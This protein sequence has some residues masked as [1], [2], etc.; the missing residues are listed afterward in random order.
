ML[1]LQEMGTAQAAQKNTALRKREQRSYTMVCK[2]ILH[3]M[4]QMLL[5]HGLR[6]MLGQTRDMAK[7]ELFSLK[8]IIARKRVSRPSWQAR[9]Q[10]M[11]RRLLHS[12]PVI[13]VVFEVAEVAKWKSDSVFRR[14]QRHPR[15]NPVLWMVPY[16]IG[17]SRQN[18]AAIKAAAEQFS[19]MGYPVTCYPSLSDFPADL[20]PDIIFVHEPYDGICF[21]K[22]YHEGLLD[23]LLCYVPY[24]MVSTKD[25]RN[26]NQVVN[27]AALFNFY[28]NEVSR[29]QACRMMDNG[30]RNSVVVGHPM[31]D[32]FLFSESEPP[33]VWK[34]CGREMKKVIWAPHWT[35]EADTCWLFYGTFM[36][37]GQA[38]LELAGKYRDRIQF[39]FKPHPN[40]YDTLCKHP[41][42][43]QEKTDAFY[44]AWEKMP[45]TQLENGAYTD[46]FMQSDA[47]VHDCGSFIQ[48]YLFADKPCLYLRYP[49]NRPE[50]SDMATDCLNA[51]H[52]G[53]EKA[54]IDL[55][56]QMVL[57]GEDPKA[58]IRQ[59]LRT[60]YLLP[61]HGCSA[62]ENMIHC[63]LG[64]R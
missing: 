53:I 6:V 62:A 37:T 39:A 61:P 28:E 50:Y 1:M 23:Y 55:F 41:E 10:V 5:P 9:T 46:L 56:L 14:M 31:A 36:K 54:D 44:R 2:E 40:L 24:G 27:N 64:T 8:C 58:A 42:W 15:F 7:R 16:P 45:N 43:G 59:E 19:A 12:K 26:L 47:M 60:K 11:H 22:R 49:D 13:N 48:E 63:L 35:I 34:D 17:N 29:S 25:A 52:T 33:V 32:P 20:H 51:Y 57:R 3:R 4:Y 18:Q 30:G 21:D 38:M